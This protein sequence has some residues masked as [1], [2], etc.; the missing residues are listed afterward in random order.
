MRWT[1]DHCSAS[2]KAE[3]I[4][5]ATRPITNA[6]GRMWRRLTSS[7]FRPEPCLPSGF[8]VVVSAQSI[9]KTSHNAA[10][11]GLARSLSKRTISN[12]ATGITREVEHFIA[13]AIESVE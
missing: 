3:E 7:D 9:A 2:R 8:T 6:F 12:V 13:E 11:T 10:E 4:N 1:S 5:P